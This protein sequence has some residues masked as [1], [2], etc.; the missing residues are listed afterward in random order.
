MPDLTARMLHGAIFPNWSASYYEIHAIWIGS[1]ASSGI[2]R[3]PDPE[4]FQIW[5]LCELPFLRWVSWNHIGSTGPLGQT[6]WS[7]GY[8]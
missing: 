8:H 4:V 1:I 7:S 5:T 3:A 2:R 6:G